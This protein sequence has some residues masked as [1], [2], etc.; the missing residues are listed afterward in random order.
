MLAGGPHSRSLGSR[1]PPVRRGL[2]A[3][4]VALAAA[5]AVLSGGAACARVGDAGEA[6]WTLCLYLCGSDLESRHAEGTRTLNALLK[7]DIPSDVRVLVQTGGARAWRIEGI[8]TG[9]IQR[10]EVRD[11]ELELLE[12]LDAASMGSGDTLGGF[13][14]FCADEA[15]S[16]RAAVV[17]WN[18][19]GGPLGGV[20]FDENE[21]YDS[22]GIDELEAALAAGAEARGG[23]PYDIAGMDACLMGSAEVAGALA[24]EARYLVASEELEPGEGWD[25]EA[26]VDALAEGPA[27]DT[28]DVAASICDAFW[29]RCE[30]FGTEASATLS[31]IDLSAMDVV[32]EALDAAIDVYADADEPK[33]ALSALADGARAAEAFGADEEEGSAPM[34]LVD[35]IGFARANAGDAGAAGEAFSALAEAA[36]NAVVHRVAGPATADA[37][38]LSFYYPVSFDADELGVYAALTPFEGYASG[39]SRMYAGGSAYVELSDA[40]SIEDGVFYARVDQASRYD[41]YDLS[42]VVR[43]IDGTPFMCEGIDIIDDWEALRFGA[44]L[45]ADCIALDGMPLDS[46]VVDAG[47]DE[48]YIVYTAPVTVNGEPANIRFAWIW[49]GEVVEDDLGPKETGPFQILGIWDGIDRVTGLSDRYLG[50]FEKGDVVCA[51]SSETLEP[52]G[53]EIVVGADAPGLDEVPLEEGAYECWFEFTDVYGGVTT[54]AKATYTIG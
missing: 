3:L 7:A 16:E 46:H 17:L 8:D 23:V 12:S 39:L 28:E 5:L 30:R 45:P 48:G 9:A 14:A 52:R 22:L 47:Y 20:C 36:D 42:L 50:S 21:G 34:N 35:L 53:D 1:R 31:A 25:Y 19:G 54:S 24:G 38:G 29:G 44:E 51:L 11:G 2:R 26:L 18:H 49:D 32:G 10:F 33:R 27:L 13:L 15:P 6:S 41:L 4:P 37:F 43:R 40:G